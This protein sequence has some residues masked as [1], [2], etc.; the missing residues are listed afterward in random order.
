MHSTM[1]VL[2]RDFPDDIT[3]LRGWVICP[4]LYCFS[5]L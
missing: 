4:V 5:R 2:G 3:Q 1:A